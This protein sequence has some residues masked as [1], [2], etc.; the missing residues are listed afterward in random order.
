MSVIF[1][2]LVM[3]VVVEPGNSLLRFVLGR[4]WFRTKRQ[5]GDAGIDRTSVEECAAFRAV[6]ASMYDQRVP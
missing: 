4:R 3:D 2:G 1:R 5:L 6:Q